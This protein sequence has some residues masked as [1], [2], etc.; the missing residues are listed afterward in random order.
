MPI[1]LNTAAAKAASLSID[2]WGGDATSRYNYLLDVTSSASDWYFENQYGLAGGTQSNSSFNAQ[3]TADA[4]VGARTIGTVPVNGWVAKDG[5]SCSF[6]QS[7]YPNQQAATSDR[8]WPRLRQRSLP[9]RSE[10]L[11]KFPGLHHHRQQ[12]H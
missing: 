10:W 8:R 12:S 1:T 6:P 11:H 4:S 7:T 9:Q 3:V 5:T 2:R